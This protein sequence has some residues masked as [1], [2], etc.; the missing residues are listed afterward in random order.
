MRICWIIGGDLCWIVTLVSL[1]PWLLNR[2]KG[3]HH[4]YCIGMSIEG[5]CRVRN[6]HGGETCAEII[7]YGLDCP[8][9]SLRW[10]KEVTRKS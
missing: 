6:M 1:N 10:C 9:I 5:T 3:I 4:C 8:N 7:C 2:L